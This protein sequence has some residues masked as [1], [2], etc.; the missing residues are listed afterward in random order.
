MT[1]QKDSG[2]DKYIPISRKLKFTSDYS[3][4]KKVKGNR[5]VYPLQVAKL[6]L[7]IR[8]RGQK[9]PVTVNEK[10]EIIDGQ[11]RVEVCEKLGIPVMYLV[12]KKASL[13]DIKDINNSAKLWNFDDYLNC[14]S[15]NGYKGAKTY[16]TL[17]SFKE[18]FDL[19][20]RIA[21]YLLSGNTHDL[22]LE[23]FRAGN[24]EIADLREAYAF[25]DCLKKIRKTHKCGRSVRFAQAL[26]NNVNIHNSDLDLDYLVKQIEKYPQKIKGPNV[27][28]F[29]DSILNCY[30]YQKRGKKLSNR[31]T[32]GKN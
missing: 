29:E 19:P 17:R 18:R 21:L 30:S 27:Q 23:D 10:M 13:D 3:I 15:R 1:D 28:E 4:F 11:H 32:V 5:R 25:G 8:A 7:K 9:V 6:L 20:G 16:L 31:K 22:G 24:F 14:Y 26:V 2:K 12:Y